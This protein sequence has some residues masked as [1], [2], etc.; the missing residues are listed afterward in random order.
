MI[1]KENNQVNQMEDPPEQYPTPPF[2][3][4]EQQVPRFEEE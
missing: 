1:S 4:Q 3:K 2:P